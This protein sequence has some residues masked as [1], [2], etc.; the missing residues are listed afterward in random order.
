MTLL[1]IRQEGS[2]AEERI[3]L[4]D[5]RESWTAGRQ[6]DCD[7]LLAH[8]TVSRHH[9]SIF[10]ENG[11]LR[12]KDLGSA[13]GTTL[14]GKRISGAEDMKPGVVVGIGPYLITVVA[15]DA[16]SLEDEKVIH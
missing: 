3:P 1:S 8:P 4:A 13:C 9:A 10:R 5:G 16:V 12:V 14:G 2:S 7:I 15:D 6:D 11:V